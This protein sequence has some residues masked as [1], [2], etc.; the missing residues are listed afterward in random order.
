MLGPSPGFV[1]ATLL[2]NPAE[3]L[4]EF[5]LENLTQ[6]DAVKTSRVPGLSPV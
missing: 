3:E 6:C 5:Q 2:P 1:Y 4:S